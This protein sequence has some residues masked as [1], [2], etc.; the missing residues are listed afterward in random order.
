MS[1]RVSNQNIIEVVRALQDQVDRLTQQGTNYRMRDLR[2]GDVILSW[3]PATN[4]LVARN[5]N[6]STSAGPFTVIATVP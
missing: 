2:I 1:V 3:I 4:Q 6:T 5:V